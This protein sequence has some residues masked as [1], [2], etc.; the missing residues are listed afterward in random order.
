MRF[1]PVAS[2]VGM[3]VV[4]GCNVGTDRTPPGCDLLQVKAASYQAKD[5]RIY[6]RLSNG[7]VFWATADAVYDS[8]KDKHIGEFE[9]GSDVI[10]CPPKK[11]E[12]TWYIHNNIVGQTGNEFHEVQGPSL[13]Q[14]PS[15]QSTWPTYLAEHYATQAIPKLSHEDIAL[16]RKTLALTSPCQRPFLRY[17]Y[18]SNSNGPFFVLFFESKTHIPH[19]L[20]TRNEYYWPDN[21][22]AAAMPGP[23]DTTSPQQE[24][25]DQPC[26]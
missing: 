26:W 13:N 11:G 21:G 7:S 1:V 15:P 20:W 19:A 4:A 24:I 6:I 16:I 8:W 2:F 10:A 14:F 12:R 18:T 3:I 5:N 17:T 25:R 23:V 9:K 22:S